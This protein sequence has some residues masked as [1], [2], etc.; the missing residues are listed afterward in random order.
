[1]GSC[2]RAALAEDLREVLDDWSQEDLIDLLCEHLPEEEM[3]Q[4]L[5]Y[6]T[7]STAEE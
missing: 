5:W 6:H 4:I 3:A 7:D 1:M 2:N